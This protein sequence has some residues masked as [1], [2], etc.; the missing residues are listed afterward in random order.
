MQ[1]L[2]DAHAGWPSFQ[3]RSHVAQYV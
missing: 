1:D 3:Q 2:P